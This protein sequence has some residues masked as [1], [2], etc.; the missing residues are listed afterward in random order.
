MVYVDH[1]PT[2]GIEV[3]KEYADGSAV[4]ALYKN[5]TTI[6]GP[7]GTEQIKADVI[8]NRIRAVT[9][10]A[11]AI[12]SKR[13]I[14]IISDCFNPTLCCTYVRAKLDPANRGSV[15]RRCGSIRVINL[16]C[17]NSIAT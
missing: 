5:K 7:D 14:S 6:T 3:Y 11:P 12:I 13:P 4:L 15:I 2:D 1:F 9:A 16:F 10:D 8:S 17:I